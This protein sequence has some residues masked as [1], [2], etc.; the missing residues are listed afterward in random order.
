M[1]QYAGAHTSSPGF[2]SAI[3]ATV[4]RRVQGRTQ[5]QQE[6]RTAVSAR[7]STPGRAILE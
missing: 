6:P 7:T 4:A 2:T 1:Y 3:T 5:K